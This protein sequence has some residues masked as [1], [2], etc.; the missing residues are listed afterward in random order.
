M[1]IIK[2]TDSQLQINNFPKGIN[3]G[4]WNFLKEKNLKSFLILNIL[5]YVA[6]EQN[7]N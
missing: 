4:F 7:W 5:I 3:K 6:N 1:H 2:F